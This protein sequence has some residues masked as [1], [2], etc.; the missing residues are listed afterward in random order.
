MALGATR[1]VTQPCPNHEAH[2]HIER[3][4]FGQRHMVVKKEATAGTHGKA[5]KERS[6]IFVQ[7]HVDQKQQVVE[8]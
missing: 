4:P 8:E 1:K 7:G 6:R 5:G 2:G 3:H